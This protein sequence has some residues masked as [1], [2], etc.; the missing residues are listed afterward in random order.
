MA[1][2]SAL[3]EHLSVAP[4]KLFRPP[5][6]AIDSPSADAAIED[7]MQV[8]LWNVDSEDGIPP[9][10]GISAEEITSNVMDNIVP[11]SIVLL[12]DGLPWSRAADAL[13]ELIER[14]KGEGY[15]LV[16][17][18]ELLADHALRR[19]S[20]TRRVLRRLGHRLGMNTGNSQAV[21]ASTRTSDA[22]GAASARADGDR[23]GHLAE[24]LEKVV[25]GR[26]GPRGRGP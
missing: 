6:G 9:W 8:I 13:P 20:P 3:I 5:F 4:P 22:N 24:L 1:A 11:G 16:T 10:E 12:H 7:G 14:L 2:C 18:S 23:S 21:A 15:R 26:R 17:V 25:E 19:P